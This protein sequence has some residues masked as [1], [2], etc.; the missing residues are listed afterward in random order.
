MRV[1]AVNPGFTLNERLHEGM[2][3]EARQRGISMEEALTRAKASRQLGR[4]AEPSEIAD[5]VVYLALNRASD[6]TGAMVA[7][8]GAVM[9]MV[10]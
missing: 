5:A 2:Q 9:P 3:A 8:D 10:V 6:I 7:T 1:N 4:I